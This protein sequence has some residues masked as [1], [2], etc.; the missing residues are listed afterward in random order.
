MLNH[1]EALAVLDKM[2][3]DGAELRRFFLMN[4]LMDVTRG[5][6][7]HGPLAGFNI[8]NRATWRASDNSAKLLGLYEQEVCSLL[9]QLSESRNTL[10]DL[11]G[12]DGFY[13]VGMVAVGKY[14]E[15][16]CFEISNESRENLREIAAANGVSEKV[17][18]YGEATPD[19]AQGLLAAGVDFSK[20][21]VLV[22]I[23][24]AEFDVLTDECL[25]NLRNAHVIV[26][27]HDFML[28][29]GVGKRK[30]ADLLERVNKVFDTCEIK[31]GARDLSAIPILS[32]HWTDTDRWLLCSESR[33]KLMS[34][35]HLSP[36][37]C[38]PKVGR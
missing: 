30:F 23:E 24:S 18:I 11:G 5:I 26:E 35:L 22:D 15:S 32:D 3:R 12:A 33:A 25:Y 7:Q 6:V 10:V 27:I 4:R 20:S 8:G 34:W 31:T 9:D 37:N 29:G 17:H 36:R 13:A 38:T 14:A 19:F 21:V 16:R 28:I 2:T 1:E